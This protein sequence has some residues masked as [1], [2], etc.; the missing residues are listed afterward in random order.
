M[1]CADTTGANVVWTLWHTAS[2]ASTIDTTDSTDP[3]RYWSATTAATT[4]TVD[5]V[6]PTWCSAE[7]A[8]CVFVPARSPSPE[9]I[10]RHQ[11]R[12]KEER[13]LR[14]EAE[15][16]AQLAE[17]RAEQLFKQIVDA[18]EF[19]AYRQ[20]GYH[21]VNG[22]DGLIYRLQPGREIK[23]LDPET[24]AHLHN[25][26]IHHR[27]SDK[28]PAVDTLISQRLCVLHDLPGLRE[29]ANQWPARN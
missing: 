16:R 5:L 17:Q 7:T 12:L 18:E 23:V 4:G 29:V 25:L 2:T 21:D 10:Q 9:E 13:R 15:R 8:S 27:Y 3:W 14:K 22:D 19:E 24:D 6:W 26:C 28:L 11:E 20:R 1:T